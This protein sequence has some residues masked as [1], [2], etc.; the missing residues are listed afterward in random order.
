MVCPC[1]YSSSLCQFT[2]LRCLSDTE[3]LFHTTSNSGN[4]QENVLQDRTFGLGS[5]VCVYVC[6][7]VCVH[8]W[9]SEDSLQEYALS[10]PHGGLDQT[11]IVKFTHHLSQVLLLLNR[12]R[13]AGLLKQQG[14]NVF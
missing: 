4:F 14:A 13:R 8:S 11:Q 6:A 12:S 10:F 7:Y 9:K 2:A 3:R 1:F 5:C